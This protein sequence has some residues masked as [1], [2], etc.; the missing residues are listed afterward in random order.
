MSVAPNDCTGMHMAADARARPL[1]T[2][3]I[4]RQQRRDAVKPKQAVDTA[5]TGIVWS[6][7]AG[8]EAVKQKTAAHHTVGREIQCFAST[9]YVFLEV[10]FRETHA[11]ANFSPPRVHVASRV[12]VCASLKANQCKLK[13][14]SCATRTSL[15]GYRHHH[16]FLQPC[17]NPGDHKTGGFVGHYL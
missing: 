9:L 6:V 1:A 8:A 11:R 12:N 16:R 2:K 10:M 7:R 13:L 14:R 17:N 5:G 4:N 15:S 3:N